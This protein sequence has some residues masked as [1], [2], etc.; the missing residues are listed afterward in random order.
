M[1][2][3]RPY[4]EDAHIA[5]YPIEGHQDIGIF[6]VFDGHG[7]MRLLYVGPEVAVYAKKYFIQCL[8][9]TTRFM[10]K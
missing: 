8:I 4:M 3:W 9:T 5:V 2:G 1:R 6:A 7:G 10:Q